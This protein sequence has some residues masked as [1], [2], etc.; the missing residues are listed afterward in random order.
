MRM[1]KKVAVLAV[2]GVTFV[3]AGTA[4]AYWTATGTGSATAAVGTAANNLVLTGASDTTALTPN[5]PT[6]FVSFTAKNPATS[7][8]RITKIHLVSVAAK[9][10]SG[11]SVSGCGTVND[12]ASAN[13]GSAD[14]YMA[15]VVPTLGDGDILKGATAQGLAAKGTLL[16]ND[17]TSDQEACKSAVLTLTFSTS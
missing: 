2:A 16:M 9:T 3:G 6:S 1:N 7:N 4:Y 14:F 17:T 15:D 11:T 8:Q 13:T 10:P 5:G 12:G